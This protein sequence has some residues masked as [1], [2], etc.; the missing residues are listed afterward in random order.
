MKSIEAE[1]RQ[2]D[3]TKRAGLADYMKGRE[4]QLLKEQREL[5]TELLRELLKVLLREQWEAS[6]V[7]QT[8]PQAASQGRA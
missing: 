5:L 6:R 3:R 4:L 1:Q 8:H 2:Q 7:F